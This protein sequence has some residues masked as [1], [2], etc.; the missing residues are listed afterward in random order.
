MMLLH[1]I[2]S[3]KNESRKVEVRLECA[4]LVTFERMDAWFKNTGFG[5][6]FRQQRNEPATANQY[7]VTLAQPN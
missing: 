5:T 7:D 2:S 3:S 1:G 4:K 6:P